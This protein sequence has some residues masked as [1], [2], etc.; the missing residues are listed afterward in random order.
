MGS[1]GRGGGGEFYWERVGEGNVAVRLPGF[2]FK[3]RFWGGGDFG[4]L[5]WAVRGGWFYRVGV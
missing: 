2:K 5:F 3:I 1:V 4:I